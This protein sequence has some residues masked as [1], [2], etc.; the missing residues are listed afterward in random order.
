MPSRL[1]IP[2]SILQSCPFQSSFEDVTYETGTLCSYESMDAPLQP[3]HEQFLK[4]LKETPQRRSFANALFSPFDKYTPPYNTSSEMHAPKKRESV[5]SSY[6]AAAEA[7]AAKKPALKTSQT[8]KKSV[9]FAKELE[10]IVECPPRSYSDPSASPRPSHSSLKPPAPVYKPVVEPP[11]TTAAIDVALESATSDIDMELPAP[12]SPVANISA[13]LMDASFDGSGERV[14]LTNLR[15]VAMPMEVE[16]LCHPTVIEYRP[17]SSAASRSPIAT[18]GLDEST[19]AAEKLPNCD[20]ITMA[21]TIR[22]DRLQNDTSMAD[23]AE[24]VSSGN[25]KA[26]TL[27][28]LAVEKTKVVQVKPSNPAAE[29]RPEVVVIETTEAAAAEKDKT[30][31]EMLPVVERIIIT[32]EEGDVCIIPDSHKD[33]VTSKETSEKS[34]SAVHITLK[35]TPRKQPAG[36]NVTKAT[37]LAPIV[38]PASTVKRPN[39]SNVDNIFDLSGDELSCDEDDPA[40]IGPQDEPVQQ[41]VP[42]NSTETTPAKAVT[43]PAAVSAGDTNSSSSSTSASVIPATESEVVPTDSEPIILPNIIE[44]PVEDDST[45]R[46]STSSSGTAAQKSQDSCKKPEEVILSDSTVFTAIDK[47]SV[48]Q[49]STDPNSQIFAL[50]VKGTE[51]PTQ[52]SQLVDLCKMNPLFKNKNVKFKIVP[53]KGSI[54]KTLQEHTQLSNNLLNKAIIV[55]RTTPAKGSNA[56]EEVASVAKSATTVVTCPSTKSSITKVSPSPASL[57]V[58]RIPLVENV[59]GPWECSICKD[60]TTSTPLKL[61]SYFEYRTHLHKVHNEPNNPIYCQHCGHKALKRNQQLYH[62]LTKHQVEPPPNV[63]FPKCDRCE[64]VGLNEY[65]LQKHQA[66]HQSTGMEYVCSCKMPFKSSELLQQH[67][68]SN[69]CK[70]S[71]SFSC[72]YCNTQFSRFVNLKAHMRVCMKERSKP[73]PQSAPV[74]ESAKPQ[75]EEPAKAQAEEPEAILP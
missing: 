62:L 23:E 49:I 55:Q 43:T 59:A 5:T 65:F 63:Q 28:P 32:R 34:S 33:V 71:S 16:V 20:D 51:N 66:L 53:V 68:A 11:E 15:N 21:D 36:I 14:E 42:I 75:A 4:K 18:N 40:P 46:P 38:P 72:G 25:S 39:L 31:V 29:E 67:I 44:K 48:S 56:R 58:A 2:D 24:M 47:K 50:K 1:E 12:L 54:S 52:L 22:V 19:P 70:T 13:D 27:A 45:L 30:E 35:A 74:V 60:K 57:R 6:L 10:V 3:V 37:P 61:S 8:P 69:S 41:P 64:F 26:T 7:P 9:T 17:R 73:A